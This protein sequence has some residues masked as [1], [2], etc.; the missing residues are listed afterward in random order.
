MYQ[1]LLRGEER[2]GKGCESESLE[3][4]AGLYS[5]WTYS[6]LNPLFKLGLE[7]DLDIEDLGA[8][9][10]RDRCGGLYD[11][12]SQYW[13]HE[14]SRPE[15]RI[16]LW[17]AMW[18]TVTYRSLIYALVLFALYA[19]LSF[20]PVLILSALVSH[21][22]GDSTLTE[23][24]LWALVAAMFV[25]PMVAS[26]M[27]SRSNAVIVHMATHTRNALVNAIF[28]K[29]LLLSPDSRQQQST[30][31]IINMFA[32]D[33]KQI[34]FFLYV[35]NNMVV[36]PFQ[37]VLIL[38]LIYLQVGVATFVGLAYMI[39]IT[40]FNGIM[41]N[42]INKTRK[43]KMKNTDYRVK[44]MN[45]VLNGIRVIK[46]YAWEAAFKEKIE[47]V[48]RIEVKNLRKMSYISA[49]GFT[50][51]FFST[52]IILPIIIFYSY[53]ML[54]NTLTAS[55]AFTT[56]A[57]FNMLL[58]PFAFLPYGIVQYLQ[59]R[60]SVQRISQFLRSNELQGYVNNIANGTSHVQKGSNIV[61]KIENA[62]MRW[63]LEERPTQMK[64][65]ADKN[66]TN[67]TRKD[68][69][70][71]S[72]DVGNDSNCKDGSSFT[73]SKENSYTVS[74]AESNNRA[75]KTLMNLNVEVERGSLVAIVGSVGSGKSSFLNTILGEM[76]MEDGGSIFVDGS[77]AYCDQ[78]PWILNATVEDN[79]LFGSSLNSVKFDKA[80][81]VSCL[82]DDLKI[83]PAGILTEI[84]ERGINLSGGQKAR[85]SLA[86]A[87]YR[88]ADIYVLDDP[89]AAVDAHVG[90]LIFQECIQGAL[91]GKTRLLVTHQLH[92][93]TECDRIIIFD[94]GR[95]KA[96]GSYAELSK[97]GIDIAAF[98]PSASDTQ[99]AA[100]SSND[101][102]QNMKSSGSVNIQ[103]MGD[104]DGGPGDVR[105]RLLSKESISSAVSF[106]VNRTL[107][108]DV[109]PA[110]DLTDHDDVEDNR[111]LNVTKLGVK[112]IPA[113]GKDLITTEELATGNVGASI[114][115]AYVQ[116]G[117]VG[118]AILVAFIMCGVQ[119]FSLGSNFYLTYW[120]SESSD[121]EDNGN[122]MSNKTNL[123][124]M[125]VFTALSVGGIVCLLIR[126]FLMS[127]IQL[128]ASLKMH[129][130]LLESVLAA[131]VSFFDVTP[132]GRIV[133]RFSSDMA[134]IDEVLAG[135]ISQA[136]N[137]L[138]SV[139]GALVA[140]ALATNGVLVILLIP[141]SV[142]Y[143][144]IQKVFRK[145][146][147]TIARLESVTRSPIYADF[148]EIL[149]G[150]GTIRAFKEEN[151][152]IAKLEA[153]VDKNTVPL[154]LQSQAGYWLG[155]R[156]DAMGSLITFF[157]AFLAVGCDTFL[158]E[159]VGDNFISAGYLA[160]GL[161]YSF[162]LTASLKFCIRVAAQLE[163]QM[164]SVERVKNYSENVDQE[165]ETV[166]EAAELPPGWP[167]VGAIE[168]RDVEMRYRDG[169]LVLKGLNFSIEEGQKVGVAGRTGSGKSSLMNALFR[170][171]KMC[172]GCIMIDGIDTRQVP[173]Q[174]LR[175][176]LG[177]IP[178]DPVMFSASVRFNLDPF[179]VYTDSE[180]WDI[181]DRVDMKNHV[182]SLPNRL[183]EEVAEG[184][185]NFSAGQRQLICIGR[186]LLRKP[187]ILVMDEATAQIDNQTDDLIQRVVRVIFKKSTV[188]TIAH[189]LNTIIN[190][191]CIMVLEAGKLGEM[192]TPANLLARKG[193]LFKSLWEMHQK[194]RRDEK[195]SKD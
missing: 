81:E 128:R 100:S 28:R 121:R 192:G 39:L 104:Y 69:A 106:T 38:Y 59:A 40:P 126:G 13:E 47:T 22:E 80:I 127:Q 111:R 101:T 151:V 34:Q 140:I 92:L 118:L 49:V 96:C 54:G 99:H 171:E 51:L 165:E 129:S 91:S 27:Q 26:L 194:S 10:K 113:S 85:V 94:E 95:I 147:T 45:E 182:S 185:D 24:Q 55:K 150:L 71:G 14:L 123:E 25:V 53:I 31:K 110:I 188:L 44:L 8:P 30:G 73:E 195:D 65:G 117:G 52:P 90:Q 163:A 105:E 130:R 86:R 168:G 87:V 107:S 21:F 184:G 159:Y 157:V 102:S 89:L 68:Q 20:I 124:Y 16:S 79:I 72:S 175:S 32:N 180:L 29:A 17:N 125:Q 176:R 19:M 83:M 7:K 12:F 145:T 119:A 141:L 160:L 178:Q 153:A 109:T 84:G 154:M 149:G 169:P 33:T 36:A 64:E 161:T 131:P 67:N 167:T 4:G 120:S 181:L 187:K 193:S 23:L 170:I 134:T 35:V 186:V 76:Y 172:N 135:S 75:M 158:S 136:T 183:E 166:G 62:S 189:R 143:Y 148:S 56:I 190:S 179:S 1:P 146:N 93:L 6:F 138:F 66:E 88:D 115:T 98:I 58:M 43:Q 57:L 174:T 112:D 108:H 77:I 133:N 132:L 191:D 3:D 177:I 37:I 46:Y 11:K 142:L 63:Q 155:I 15:K 122:S 114:Y 173:L 2:S 50:L 156:L 78:R 60:V 103:I 97:S 41:L 18:L 42:L 74:A 116:A 9:A 139:F 82:A 70:R 164:N 137:S 144:D 48:R 5:L 162:S 152:F 61:I